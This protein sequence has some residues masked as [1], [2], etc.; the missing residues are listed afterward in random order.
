MIAIEVLQGHI[1]QYL[2][3]THEA[4]TKA[5]RDRDFKDGKQWTAQEAATLKGRRQ[6]P[7]VDNMIKPKVEGIKGLYSKRETKPKAFART[8]KHEKSGQAITDA[9]RYITDKERFKDTKLEVLD[10]VLVEGVGGGIVEVTQRG[11][12]L[13]INVRAIPA[14]R[15]YYDPY[16][17]RHDFDDTMY[18]GIMIWM[19]VD[20]AKQVFK[21]KSK[22]IEEA[23]EINVTT[24]DETFEDRPRFGMV[25]EDRKRILVAQ[26][27]FL[28]DSVWHCAVFT[29]NSFL[30]KPKLSPFL[31]DYGD[32]CCPIELTHAYIDREGQ[33]YGEVRGLID[34]Q[35]EVNHRR[36]R[37]LFLN[38]S[39]QTAS[40][41]GAI[42]DVKVLK[43]ELAQPDGHVEVEG[44]I[45]KAFQVLPTGDFAQAQFLLYQDAKASLNSVS[46]NAALSGES[47]PDQS[48]RAIDLL[49]N[50]SV[51]ELLSLLNNVS[52]WESRMLRQVWFR[53]KQFWTEEK[54]VRVTD[55][56]DKLRWVGL[57]AK[58]TRGQAMQDF[59]N[60]KSNP[61]QER[62]QTAQMLQML[63][64]Q[65]PQALEE[66]IEVKNPVPELDMD[67]MLETATSSVNQQQ[68]EL[69]MIMELSAANPGQVPFKSILK[70][71]TLRDKEDVIKDIEEREQA[72]M[73]AQQQMMQL[74]TADKTVSIQG[75]QISNQLNSVK[76]EEAGGKAL[77]LNM[78]AIG[79]QIANEQLLANPDPHP[80]TSV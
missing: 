8:Q 35:T 27:W 39:R 10:S 12:D 69:R 26:E 48:G 66:V 7:I 1:S 16:S 50:A 75:K 56:Y 2:D 4:R 61:E 15:L 29:G 80:Q 78:D 72:Q 41:K 22:E 59:I 17:R 30:E 19:D 31:D 9:V 45:N 34:P 53:I 38:T 36:S 63:S 37:F 70:M 77:N 60:D 46:F 21:G 20:V 71:T 65:Q 23:V 67:I 40:T 79:K 18:R 14:D 11:D 74:E 33:R 68:E 25:S 58:V 52:S 57:N 55:D 24:L 64:Q 28:H 44:E 51:L 3:L 13:E 54:W 47:N 62:K 32:P 42:K 49:Q 43:R 6:A 73:A 5:E 76:I